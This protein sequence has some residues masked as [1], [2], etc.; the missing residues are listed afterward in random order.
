MPLRR[1]CETMLELLAVKHQKMDAP[2][3][4]CVTKG[5]DTTVVDLG[6]DES[7]RIKITAGEEWR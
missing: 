5:E 3:S 1:V 7:G 4:L 6:L 2:E